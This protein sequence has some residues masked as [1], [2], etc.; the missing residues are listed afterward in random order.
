MLV[1][2]VISAENQEAVANCKIDGERLFFPNAGQPRA[3]LPSEGYSR[4]SS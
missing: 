1:D 3:C 4:F 2:R